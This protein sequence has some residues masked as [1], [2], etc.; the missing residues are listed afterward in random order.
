M[1]GTKTE[2]MV[3]PRT[4]DGAPIPGG[5]PETDRPAVSH[6]EPGPGNVVDSLVETPE[7]RQEA[8][9]Q[10]A[11]DEAAASEKADRSGR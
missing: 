6:A 7:A 9:E 2:T 10:L 4:V 5:T 11:R 8:G 3:A 1:D